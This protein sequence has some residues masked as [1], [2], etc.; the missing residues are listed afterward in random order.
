MLYNI[1]DKLKCKQEVKSK[2]F[3]MSNLEFIINIGDVYIITDKDDYP[4]DN[5]CHWY[6][7]TSQKDTS[8]II[9][10]WN[11]KPDRMMVDDNFEKIIK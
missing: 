3:E 8:V 7:L 2:C 5:N 11:D 4:D 10:V 6:E 9:N 1:G